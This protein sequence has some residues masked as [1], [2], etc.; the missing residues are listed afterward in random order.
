M[1]WN[2]AWNF[3]VSCDILGRRLMLRSSPA[4]E[5][6]NSDIAQLLYVL[7]T[8]LWSLDN[9]MM[10]HTTSLAFLQI[11]DTESTAISS[12]TIPQK[13]NVC[14]WDVVLISIINL[15][16]FCTCVCFLVVVVYLIIFLFLW[17]IVSLMYCFSVNINNSYLFFRWPMTFLALAA[18]RA[19]PDF[20]FITIILIHFVKQRCLL[21]CLWAIIPQ[22]F[23]IMWATHNFWR[24]LC[25]IMSLLPASSV[26]NGTAQVNGER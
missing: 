5:Q 8:W 17:C 23:N 2:L 25:D 13:H 16:T 22:L 3:C 20:N 24:I 6:A 14:K 19:C 10:S 21:G 12:R 11:N 1:V 4:T 7:F 18:C 15:L 26:R 9:C